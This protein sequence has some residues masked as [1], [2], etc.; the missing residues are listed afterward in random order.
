MV[1]FANLVAEYTQRL[2]LWPGL[3]LSLPIAALLLWLRRAPT[4][5]P[6]RWEG[7]LPRPSRWEGRAAPAVVGMAGA[8]LLLALLP[9]P[10]SVGVDWPR[11]GLLPS[12]LPRGDALAA[13]L[14]LPLANLALLNEQ[15]AA[16]RWLVSALPALVGLLAAQGDGGV[17]PRVLAAIA[18]L[19]LLLVSDALMSPIS[20]PR[21]V[22]W[23]GGL[24]QQGGWLATIALLLNLLLPTLPPAPLPAALLYA[25]VA[26]VAAGAARA[27]NWRWPRLARRMRLVAAAA[28]LLALLLALLG[29]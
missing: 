4:P 22:R 20:G 14:L 17:A 6:S 5:R 2:L 25:G 3:G 28:A 23:M 7:S 26:I 21:G 15:G 27:A 16:W 18:C 19:P 8:W 24:A 11:F 9:W 10:A 12:G 1:D 29:R 13:L